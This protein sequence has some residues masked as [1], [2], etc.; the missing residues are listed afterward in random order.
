MLAQ[1]K[2][3]SFS[4]ASELRRA[5]EWLAHDRRVV[6]LGQAVKCKGTA[7]S[8][9]LERI[10]LQHRC[11]EM[12]VCEEL[13]MGLSIGMS[14]RGL[15]PVSIY[16]R[17]NF[18][19]LAT[20]QIVNHLDKLPLISG[21]KPKVIVRVGVGS[22]R[23]LYPGLQHTGDFSDAFRSMCKSIHIEQLTEPEL[24]FP[25]YRNAFYRNGSS[26]L[27]EYGDFYNEK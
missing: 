5:M 3:S 16:P 6:F 27:V 18:L 8:G 26:I 25:A 1:E 17:W 24:V 11:I 13:Q 22:E 23:P 10:P 7:M 2:E 15:I 12:P 9:T 21:Y 4:Y 19:L 20:N 14:L